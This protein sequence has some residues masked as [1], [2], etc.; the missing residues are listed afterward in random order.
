MVKG[1]YEAWRSIQISSTVEL[2][3]SCSSG[4]SAIWALATAGE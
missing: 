4:R 2:L 1:I 3:Q